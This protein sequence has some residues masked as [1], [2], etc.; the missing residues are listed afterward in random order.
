[1][2][3]MLCVHDFQVFYHPYVLNASLF[4]RVFLVLKE[5]TNTNPDSGKEYG[6]LRGSWRRPGQGLCCAPRSGSALAIAT[7]LEFHEQICLFCL[8][9]GV[10]EFSLYVTLVK[11]FF[12]ELRVDLL[13]A[14]TG[15]NIVLMSFRFV[16]GRLDTFQVSA[17]LRSVLSICVCNCMAIVGGRERLGLCNQ[18]TY[19]YVLNLVYH[20]AGANYLVT[21]R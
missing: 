7:L 16:S 9:A 13:F 1:M 15:V 19:C 17:F 3:C 4:S 6:T 14:L 18:R 2:K 8:C 11:L 21:V 10:H 5:Q 12:A 20:F